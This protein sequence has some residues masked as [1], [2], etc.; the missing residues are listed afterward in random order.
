MLEG[1]YGKEPFDLRLTVLRMLRNLDKIMV[2]TLAGTLLF[3]GAYYVKNVLLRGDIQYST[4]STYKVEYSDPDWAVSGTYINGATWDTHVHTAE[5]LDMVKQFLEQEPPQELPQE[6]K[7][8]GQQP[9]R[10]ALG[11]ML[12][13]QLPSDLRVL[14]VTVTAASAEQCLQVAKAVERAMTERF[15]EMTGEV[16][17]IRL[18][19]PAKEAAE[20]LPDVRPGRAFL[21]SGLLSFFFTVT[22][23]LLKETGDDCIWLPATLRRRY[24]VKVLG[25]LH[26]RELSENIGY[27]F[28]GMKRAAVCPADSSID[29]AEAAGKL[30]APE[31]TEWIPAPA[32][33]LCPQVCEALRQADGI[34]LVLRAG[35]NAGRHFEYVKEYLEQQD[36]RITAVLL[37]EADE[38]LIKSYYGFRKDEVR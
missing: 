22:L 11:E 21:L 25:T 3:G 1:S 13:A 16:S 31:G 32:P 7:D 37:W 27:L 4:V 23:L 6:Q 26:S 14:T 24:G 30:P 5:F 19:D 8:S 33:L 36:C 20:V 29:S 35:A 2:F 18:I 9:S 38:L 10:E 12:K 17:T 28:G 34:L 15:P